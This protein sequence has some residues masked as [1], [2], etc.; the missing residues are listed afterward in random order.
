MAVLFREIEIQ[1]KDVRIRRCRIHFSRR[2]EGNSGL[3]VAHKVHLERKP[4]GVNDVLDE[5][6]VGEIVFSH[7]K[8]QP[9]LS[10]RAL[11]RG[12]W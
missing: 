3:A 7:Q 10:A 2:N 6:G 4:L 5:H 12:G 11:L 8:I 1:N 9:L